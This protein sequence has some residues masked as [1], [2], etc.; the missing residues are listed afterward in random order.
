MNRVWFTEV[1][2]NKL[3][4]HKVKTN[5]VFESVWLLDDYYV[6]IMLISIRNHSSHMIIKL[7]I[8][9][10]KTITHKFLFLFF[11][12]LILYTSFKHT[13]SMCFFPFFWHL[14]ASTYLPTYCSFYPAEKNKS[15]LCVVQTHP[16]VI[17]LGYVRYTSYS[18]F[19]Q[20]HKNYNSSYLSLHW[21]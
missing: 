18:L 8:F 9:S 20:D 7:L 14:N 12:F 2:N 15:A 6:R 1:I 13:V 16:S 10:P 21:V 11:L 5:L 4:R 3:C 17:L 19:L